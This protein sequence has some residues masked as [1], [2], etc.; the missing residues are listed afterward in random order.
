VPCCGMDCIPSDMG[1]YMM[2]EHLKAKYSRQTAFVKIG[3]LSLK[4]GG[5]SGGTLASIF[6]GFESGTGRQTRSPY[7]LNPPEHPTVK[8]GD[9]FKVGW[10]RDL[11]GWT[12]LNPLAV[13]DL[14]VVNRS[15]AL[16]N[17]RYGPNFKLTLCGLDRKWFSAVKT[18]LFFSTLI[19]LCAL[20]PT[21]WR[22][23]KVVRAPGEGPT[24][25]QMR[26]GNL[27]MHLVA[28][29]EPQ[30]DEPQKVVYGSVECSVDA[31]YLGTS[32]M[33]GESALTIALSRDE[34]AKGGVLTTASA[35]GPSLLKRLRSIGM[36]FSVDD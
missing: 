9:V 11:R 31:G 30:N 18:F 34:L 24:R 12:T 35:F 17:F 1:T 15:N 28:G 4:G 36:T 16:Q 21:R 20:A 27:K 7:Y 19:L 2:V 14:R 13:T 8:S 33:L 32:W 23:K 5:P 22:L 3:L 25:E 6:N 10:D 29:T 26:K